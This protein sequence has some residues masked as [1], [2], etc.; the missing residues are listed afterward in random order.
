MAAG[1]EPGPLFRRQLNGGLDQVEVPP[2]AV[3]GP[4][5]LIFFKRFGF[6]ARQPG[7][8]SQLF[9][10]QKVLRL[11]AL[12]GLLRLGRRRKGCAK[13]D[14]SSDDEAR[15]ETKTGVHS[16]MLVRAPPKR[17]VKSACLP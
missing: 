2:E 8:R 15:T 17:Q 3:I 10:A 13:N 4:I 1:F 16:V 6:E 12:S 5:D 9:P 14:R 11:R 7:M